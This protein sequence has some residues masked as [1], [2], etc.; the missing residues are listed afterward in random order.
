MA[1][2][3]NTSDV[4]VYLHKSDVIKKK[5]NTPFKTR[6]VSHPEMVTREEYLFLLQV[7]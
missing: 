5:E 6:T 7:Y 4:L 2:S 1:R 3:S